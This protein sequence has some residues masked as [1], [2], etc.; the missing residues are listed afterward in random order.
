VEISRVCALYFSPTGTTQK[1]TVKVAAGTGIPFETHDLTVPKARQ[2]FKY[3]FRRNDLLVIGLPVYAGRLPIKIDDFFSGLKGDATPAV[4]LVVYGNREYN[5]ALVELKLRLEGRG[6]IVKA[7]AAFV[8]EHT[9][10]HKIA[11]G[12]PDANDLAIAHDFGRKTA[13]SIANDVSGKLELKGSYPFVW[14]GYDPSNPSTHP[15]F[16]N[17]VTTELCTSCGLCAEEC[18]WGAIEA[19]NPKR[20]DSTRCMRCL[21]CLKNCPASAKQIIDDKFLAFL[22]QFETKLNSRRCEPELFLAM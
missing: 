8:G 20:I 11:T 10:S 3:S 22:P 12:R 9:F 7:G 16:F 5:D 15:T 6:F 19:G 13:M 2:T 18:P 17:I 21:R 1:A 4:A 14:K